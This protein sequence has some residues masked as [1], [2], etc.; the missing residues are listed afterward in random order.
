MSF[1]ITSNPLMG[2][3]AHPGTGHYGVYD[4]GAHVWAWQPSGQKPILWTSAESMYEDGA[5]IRGGVPVIFPWF[6]M[7]PAGALKPAHGF[8]RLHPWDRSHVDD[9]IDT[10]GELVVEYQ[11][12]QTR[13]GAQTDFPYAFDAHLRVTFTPEYLQMDLKVHNAGEV[14]FTFEE[15]LHTYIAVGDVNHISIEGLEGA[16]Y[17]DRVPG[18]PQLECVQDG[19]VTITS[20]TDRLYSHEGTVVLEDP[21]WGRRLG[22]SKEGSA[23]TV[24]WN[25]WIAKSA[26][27]SDFGDD[28]W[29]AMVCVEAA[30]A[31]DDAIILAPGESHLMRQRISLVATAPKL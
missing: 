4:H 19:P 26:A 9:T 10:D 15:A 8:A 16:S 29:G 13:I 12:D 1:E 30:N 3:E 2:I 24:V 27:M 5:A 25:P 11:I 28:E 6:G 21:V 23:N 7:G 20:E 31:L 18:A 14:P 17:L 22:I